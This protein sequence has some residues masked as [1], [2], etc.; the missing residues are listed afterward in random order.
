MRRNT[1]EFTREFQF[2]HQV[3][4]GEY[5]RALENIENG[6]SAGVFNYEKVTPFFP[7]NREKSDAHP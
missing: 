4:N 3:H 6:G 7:E 5:Y 2:P 1:Q